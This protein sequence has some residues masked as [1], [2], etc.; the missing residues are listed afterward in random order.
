MKI[1]TNH[2][3][4]QTIKLC[5][6]DEE[7]DQLLIGLLTP[8]EIEVIATRIEIAR[9][10]LKG[11]SQRSVAKNLGI[12]IATVTRGAREVRIGRFPVLSRTNSN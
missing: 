12:G 11:E 4:I 5:E 8:Q 9:R 10:L 3:L 2:S 6:S 7:L 1:L